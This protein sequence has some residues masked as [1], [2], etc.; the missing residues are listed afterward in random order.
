MM[1]VGAVAGWTVEVRGGWGRKGEGDGGTYVG[2]KSEYVRR[3]GEGVEDEEG[4]MGK[5]RPCPGR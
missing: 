3:K 1:K 4:E 5:E 2:M